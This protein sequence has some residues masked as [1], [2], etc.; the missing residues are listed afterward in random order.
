MKTFFL[1]FIIFLSIELSAQECSTTILKTKYTNTDVYRNG[2]KVAKGATYTLNGLNYLV[3]VEHV[4]HAGRSD[5]FYVKTDSG[6]FYIQT[7]LKHQLDGAFC[8]LDTIPKKILGFSNLKE[9][10]NG[11]VNTGLGEHKFDVVG[12]VRNICGNKYAS[13][14]L[15]EDVRYDRLGIIIDKEYK[16]GESGTLFYDATGVYIQSISYV[17]KIIKKD[18]FVTVI[19]PLQYKIVREGNG[20]KYL[21]W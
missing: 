18:S 5:T 11:I 8:L 6:T 1:F 20:V 4:F 13:L 12:Y 2:V 7:V 16:P 9:M 19:F 15:F 17:S 3:T 10:N 14:G 21:P